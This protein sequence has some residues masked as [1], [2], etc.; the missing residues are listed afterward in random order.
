MLYD[1]NER[2]IRGEVGDP[3]SS[4]LDLSETSTYRACTWLEFPVGVSW[5]PERLEVNG[6]KG[7]RAI[8]V[9]AQD[10][11]HYRIYDLDSSSGAVDAQDAKTEGSDE[12]VS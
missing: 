8:C 4:D 9:L 5:V 7:R 11:L 2:D 1:S 12:I 3:C 10:R 6:S